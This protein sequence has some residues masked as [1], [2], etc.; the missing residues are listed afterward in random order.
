MDMSITSEMKAL[1]RHHFCSVQVSNIVKISKVL[2]SQIFALHFTQ[3]SFFLSQTNIY[4]Y[5]YI[6]M[7]ISLGQKKNIGIFSVITG[8]FQGG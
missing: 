7:L 1:L 3:I 8:Q 5:I 6:Y 2:K 4:I